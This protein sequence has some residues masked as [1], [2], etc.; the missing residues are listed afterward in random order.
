MTIL[1]IAKWQIT[2][3]YKFQFFV[4][5]NFLA[6]SILK[7][8][9]HWSL[10]GTYFS[11]ICSSFLEKWHQTITSFHNFFPCRYHFSSENIIRN[12][13]YHY[14]IA[15]NHNNLEDITNIG[16]EINKSFSKLPGH[17]WFFTK[18]HNYFLKLHVKFPLNYAM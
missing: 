1:Q 9:T 15:D 16:S 4:D 18:K 12:Q 7:K 6:I 17:H 14:Y 5:F 10:N 3:I 2:H 8:I 13:K 11:R